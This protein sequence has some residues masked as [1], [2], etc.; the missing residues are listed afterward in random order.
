MLNRKWW[1]CLGGFV[2]LVGAAFLA[3]WPITPR[4]CITEENLNKIGMGMTE[5]E[6]VQILGA[7]AGDYSTGKHLYHPELIG[8]PAR[9]YSG[10]L[11]CKEWVG[12]E[13]KIRVC[14]EA[15]GRV[16]VAYHSGVFRQEQGVLDRLRRWLHLDP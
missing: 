7:P 14:F 2:L 5:D 12:D 8:G 1:L 13:G 15:S 9:V 16:F 6:V 11:A 10:R 4:H 3:L